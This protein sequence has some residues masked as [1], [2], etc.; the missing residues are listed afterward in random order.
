MIAA[1]AAQEPAVPASTASGDPA[2]QV[3]LHPAATTDAGE[4]AAVIRAA[5]GARPRLGPPPSG[6]SETA[7]SVAAKLAAGGGFVAVTDRIVGVV[8]VRRTGPVARL[9]RVCVLPAHQHH[10]LAAAMVRESA[11]Q[12]AAAGVARIEAGVRPEYPGLLAWWLDNDFERIGERDGLILVARA[13]PQHVAVPDAGA[14]RALG[15]RIAVHLRPGDVLIESGELGAG[16]TTLTQGI[17]A[18]L[19]VDRPVISPTFVLS[20]VHPS[21]VG[22]PALVHVDAYRLGSWDELLDLDLDQT[23]ADSV[24]VVEWGTGIAEPLAAD[25]LEIDIRRDDPA[26][27]ERQVFLTGV[28]PRWDGVTL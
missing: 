5:F 6:L 24:T 19:H 17:G 2:P 14:M 10:G 4:I 8:L 27:D 9:E 21:L 16:K 18:G 7:E 13:A 3:T 15:E 23:L 28:G 1:D 12:L 22:G 25:R 11:L 20:R 26:T